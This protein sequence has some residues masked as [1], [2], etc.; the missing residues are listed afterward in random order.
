MSRKDNNTTKE[1][2]A[3]DEAEE[4]ELVGSL[5]PNLVRTREKPTRQ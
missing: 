4:I 3:E 2:M 5:M 1:V